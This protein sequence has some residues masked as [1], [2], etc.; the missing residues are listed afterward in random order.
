MLVVPQLIR[1]AGLA[2]LMAPLLA[3]ALN[4]VPRHE[5]PMASVFLNVTQNVGGSLGIA[6]L[7]NYV[8]NSIHIHAVRLGEVVPPQSMEYFRLARSASSLVLRG[9]H[10]V[11]STHQVKAAFAASQSV[12][13][14]SQVLGFD[15]GFVFAGVIVLMAIPLCLML[16]PFAHHLR[17]EEKVEEQF[18]AEVMAD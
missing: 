8:T 3:T 15:N 7:N 2:L 11:L 5:L 16:K 6:L 17:E 9:V 12:A 1:G 10:G 14:R 18:E 13:L 4:S